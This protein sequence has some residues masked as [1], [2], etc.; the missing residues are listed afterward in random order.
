MK[1]ILLIYGDP[2]AEAQLSEAQMQAIYQAHE[3]Y[4]QALE[5]AGVMRGGAE[6]KPPVPEGMWVGKLGSEMIVT[7]EAKGE[8]ARGRVVLLPEWEN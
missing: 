4:G 3:A 7:V 1:Y 2:A 6:L 8:P 5:T